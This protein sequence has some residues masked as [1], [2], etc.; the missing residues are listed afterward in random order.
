MRKLVMEIKCNIYPN[1][2]NN[3]LPFEGTTHRRESVRVPRVENDI[4]VRRPDATVSASGLP[5]FIEKVKAKVVA[6]VAEYVQN[7]KNNIMHTYEHKLVYALVEKELYG[8]NTLDAITHDSDKMIMYLL[9]FP[10][11]FVSK[12]HRK[13]SEHHV[14][15]GKKMNLTSMLTDNIAS[16]PEFKPDKKYSL[17][18]FYKR[19]PELQNVKG[20]KRLLDYY[21]FGENIDFN[22]IKAMKESKY[23]GIKGVSLATVKSVLLLTFLK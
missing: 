13:H 16:S 22:K 9:G 7:Y 2:Y 6:P 11:S 5:G 19:S 8:H 4:Y 12:F 21:N 18:E 3:K 15:S 20:F 1:Y 17:R 14:E 10:K 23:N